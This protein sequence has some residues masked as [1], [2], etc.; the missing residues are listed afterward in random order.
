MGGRVYSNRTFNNISSL[1]VLL[2]SMLHVL[3]AFELHYK[4]TDLSGATA[5]EAN[6]T[7]KILTISSLI[8]IA[9]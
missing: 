2:E 5:N 4:I 3:T 7:I 1:N 8:K 6:M 9:A